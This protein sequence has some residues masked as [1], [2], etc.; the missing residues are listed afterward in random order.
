MK[1]TGI[2]ELGTLVTDT[3]HTWGIFDLVGLIV[4]LGSFGALVL[5]IPVTGKGLVVEQNKMKFGTQG[6][7]LHIYGVPMTL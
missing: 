1:R 6:H 4:I 5:K 2:W 7:Y 3:M